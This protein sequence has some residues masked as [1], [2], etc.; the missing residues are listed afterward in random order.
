MRFFQCLAIYPDSSRASP[1]VLVSL[2]MKVNYKTASEFSFL[3]ALP[4]IT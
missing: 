1:T 4:V 2:L 3:I